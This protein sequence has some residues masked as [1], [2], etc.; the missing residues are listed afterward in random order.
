MMHIRQL[1]PDD[2]PAIAALESRFRRVPADGENGYR[3]R[4]ADADAAGVHLSFGLFDD[5]RLAGYLLCYGFRPTLFPG[6]IGETLQ[7]EYVATL[8]RYRRLLPRLLRRL[9]LEARRH[10]PGSVIEAHMLESAFKRWCGHAAFFARGGYALARGADTGEMLNGE[11][12]YRS[13]WQP[14][15]DWDPP[16]PTVDELVAGLPGHPVAVDGVAY[17]AKVVTEERDWEALAP[18]WDRFLLALPDHSVFQT[19]EYQ[20]LWWRHLEG[21]NELYIVLLV[22]DGEIHGIAPLH[23]GIVKEYGRWLRRLAFIGS[24]EDAGQPRLLF[25]RD[26]TRLTRAL[27]AFLAARP[28]RWDVGDFHR[29]QAGSDVVAVF[30]AAFRSA[31]YLVGRTRDA[32]TAHP[33]AHATRNPAARVTARLQVYPRTPFFLALHTAL[34]RI[35]PRLGGLLRPYI[36]STT[37]YLETG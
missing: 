10:F 15:P 4:L 24:R 8:P 5:D 1:R 3:R 30:E 7:V 36:P 28:L 13:R 31:G 9:G 6:E 11:I 26:G 18:L 34:F 33:A 35:R 23:V 37:S 2:A 19:C 22:R 27:V 16:V 21:D 25:P 29:Q 20:R 14:I 17:E 12:R 32:A